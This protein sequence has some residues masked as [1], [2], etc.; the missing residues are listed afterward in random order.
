MPFPI[1]LTLLSIILSLVPLY[2]LVASPFF[3][4]I[5]TPS[6]DGYVYGSGD[7][8]STCPSHLHQHWLL[9]SLL[10]CYTY[11]ICHRYQYRTCC[12]RIPP[13]YPTHHYF[14]NLRLTGIRHCIIICC[15]HIH[16]HSRRCGSL[17][18]NLIPIFLTVNLPY[19]TALALN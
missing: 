13:H 17:I 18:L 12:A 3:L 1:I 2:Y 14:H 15:S 4:Y 10:I 9:P 11:D 5:Y 16:S 7:G 19:I 8:A 6:Q